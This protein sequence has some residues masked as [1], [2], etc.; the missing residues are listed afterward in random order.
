MYITKTAVTLLLACTMLLCACQV[1]PLTGK[2]TLN[3]YSYEDEKAI[4]DENVQPIVAE[5][6]GLYPDAALQNYV[7]TVGQKVVTAGRSR[8][9]GEAGFPDWD[10]NFYVVNTSMINAFALPGGHVF[11]TR[12]ILDRLKDESELAGLLGHEVAHVFARHS[13]ER[14]SEMTMM[15]I[16]AA[17]L[18]SFEETEGLAVV[19]IVAIQLLALKY[20]RDNESESDTFGMR[21]AARAG[22]RPDGIIG[23][24]QMLDEMSAEHGGGG[25]EFLSTHPDPGNR[26]D[27][28]TRQMSK[29][30][31]NEKPEWFRGDV[32]Y[33]GAL[34]SM[35]KAQPA[36]VLADTGDA[37][38]GQGFEL[39]NNGNVEGAKA[40]Y[41]EALDNYRA[42]A[43]AQPGH[44][45][46]HVNLAQAQFYLGEYAQAERHS[47]DA[48]NLEPGSFWPN[49]MGGLVAIKAGDNGAAATRLAKALELIPGSPVSM[50]Y[51]A[52]AY[53]RNQN[54]NGATEYYRRAY[55]AF[56]GEGDM[57]ANARQ[58]LI[59]M[60]QPD[61]APQP[62]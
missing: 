27:N 59:E 12:G 55:N 58:R 26:V 19:G 25:P 52:V 10:F 40:K 15:I 51:L 43:S 2:S 1:D 48:L 33:T 39:F 45:I 61:P 3:L 46:L 50:Y 6:G 21:F 30:Y 41:R 23:V 18:A 34:V 24:M 11:V 29:E 4:G 20:S 54:T 7:N 49:F 32:E 56:N 37:L 53:D 62:K 28:L 42:A 31:G 9:K 38:M 16:P 60:G 36:Y 13:V 22:Y 14:M 44:A 47:R 5:L 17:L 35:R 57:A 8:L